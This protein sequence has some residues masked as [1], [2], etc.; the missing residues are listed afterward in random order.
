MFR[1]RVRRR[2]V[3]VSGNSMPWM[4][5]QR[6][7]ERLL[8]ALDPQQVSD[9]R[10]HGYFH[11]RSDRGTLYKITAGNWTGNIRRTADNQ[12]FC[13]HLHAGPEYP[14]DDHLLAQA[15]LIRTDEIQFLKIAYKY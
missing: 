9:L 3:P 12:R 13:M 5:G 6:A 8:A 7:R 1:W 11:V 10:L 4:P 14:V 2:N 15:L